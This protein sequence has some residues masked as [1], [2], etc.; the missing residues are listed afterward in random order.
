MERLSNGFIHVHTDNSMFDSAM[1]VKTLCKKAKELGAPAVALTDHG[2]LSGIMDFVKFAKEYEIK[3]VLG[4]EGYLDGRHIVLLAIDYTGYIAIS[5]MM[6]EAENYKPNGKPQLTKEILENY[7]SEGKEGHGHIIISSACMGGIIASILLKNEKLEGKIKKEKK[8]QAKQE[9]PNNPIY[10]KMCKQLND[11][12]QKI[13]F[14]IEK[15]DEVKKIAN[16]SVKG[17]EN[18]I[19]KAK[20]EESKTELEIEL[21]KKNE[22]KEKASA[23]YEEIVENIALLA[24]KK[25]EFKK[26]I[27]KSEESQMRF[28]DIEKEINDLKE[29]M[30]PENTLYQE[31]KQEAFYFENLCGRNNFYM[32]IQYHGIEAEKKCMTQIAKI[33]REINLPL[34]A[35]NDAHMPTNSPDDI[36]ARQLMRSGYDGKWKE[37]LQGDEELYLKTDEELRIALKRIF[38]DD[39]VNEAMNNVSVVL[40]RCNVKFERHNFYPRFKCPDGMTA[41]EML[42]KLALQ[43]KKEKFPEGWSKEYEKRLEMELETMDAMDVNDY[44]LIVWDLINYGR[45]I[46]NIP[47]DEL[48]KVPLTIEGAK[49]WVEKKGYKIGYGIGP[50]RGSAA[51]S[52]VCYLIG[53][54]SLD[55]IKYGLL[56]ARYL[57]LERVTMPDIDTDYA[58]QVREKCMKYARA[59]YGANAVCN[60]MT[61][62]TQAAR[63]AIRNCTRYYS[64]KKF[65][66]GTHLY[67]LGDEIAKKIPFKPGIKL[68][69]VI[70]DLKENYKDNPDALEIIH[71]ATLVEGTLNSY[72]MHAAGV[73]IS[74]NNDIRTHI[75]LRKINDA[76]T[77]QCDMVQAEELGLLK[78]DFL[79]LKNLNILTDAAKMIYKNHGILIDYEKVPL[80]D[81]NVLKCIFSKGMTNGVFQFESGGMKKMLQNFKPEDFTDLILL[82]ACYRPGPMQFLDG[83]AE[84]NGGIN[85]IK[86]KNGKQNISYL[87]PQLESILK[88][89]YGAIVYQEQVMEICQK[90]AGYTL[91][92][93]DIV[94]RYMSKK[95]TEKLE[96]ERQSFI[97]GDFERNIPGCIKNGIPEEIANKIFDQM[98]DFAKYAFNKSHAACYAKVSYLTGYIKYYYPEEFLAAMIN[99]SPDKIRECMSDAKKLNIKVLPPDVNNSEHGF[100]CSKGEIR[101]GL[102]A[103]KGVKALAQEIEKERKTNGLFHSMKEFFERTNVG[104]GDAE[105]LIEAGAL[106]CF[107]NNRQAMLNVKDSIIEQIKTI[108]EKKQKVVNLLYSEKCLTQAKNL[109]ELKEMMKSTGPNGEKIDFSKDIKRMPTVKKIELR[110]QD[111]HKKLFEAKRQLSD[112]RIPNYLQEN[113]K[114]KLKREKERIGVYISGHPLDSYQKPANAVDIDS[115]YETKSICLY[116]MVTDLRFKERASDRKPMA[117]FTL[118]D[119]TSV[120]DVCVFTKEFASFGYLLEEGE[121]VKITGQCVKEEGDGINDEDEVEEK[122]KIFSKSL[123]VMKENQPSVIIE[124][125]DMYEWQTEVRNEILPYILEGGSKL[126]VFD[127]MMGE[128]RETAYYVSQ[129]IKERIQTI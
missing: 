68:V 78:M 99:W 113:N 90:L 8:K 24:S 87:V 128:M 122:L 57:N 59:K 89:T 94:R 98:I 61:K 58:N 106:D 120:V 114:Y 33:A 102:N 46:Q 101:F 21:K 103:I 110:I 97:C 34:L 54:T 27:K 41:K 12:E 31:A 17:L 32:E 9:R 74:D 60:I 81:K 53:I 13:N 51:G 7:M 126:F 104:T 20:T 63:G 86:V 49:E 88:D 23:I 5:K 55:P 124:V 125:K 42:R 83:T 3:P 65:G 6:S 76:W 116:G 4:V 105:A 93:A 39:I 16:Q 77:T 91:G 75:P 127:K 123:T 112:I 66:D 92:Q 80:N 30:E 62:N 100:I 18:K 19:K 95:K 37:L 72:G 10:L 109:E 79:G 115:I 71:M 43:G 25:S 28:L 96:H 52:L 64:D 111:A 48:P 36:L 2:T 29:Q 82:V 73:I 47:Y 22:E 85:I 1:T 107:S 38:P 56:F 11:C 117:F 15:R 70:D 67:D 108:R 14:L 69:D 121:I 44:H 50:G 129:K 84:K 119:K 35:T 26:I 45:T 118:E 40:E